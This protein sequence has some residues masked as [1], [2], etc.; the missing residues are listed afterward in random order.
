MGGIA[1]TAYKGT[2]PNSGGSTTISGRITIADAS[3]VFF[4]GDVLEKI[5]ANTGWT[6]GTVTGTCVYHSDDAGGGRMC[7][8]VVAAGA[9]HGD[10]GSPVFWQDSNGSYH[11]MGILWGGPDA[12]PG[13]QN[14]SEFWFS[15]R[16][17]IV[18]DLSPYNNLLVTPSG[19]GSGCVPQP[20]QICP[21]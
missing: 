10:S 13:G 7:N 12:V 2:G 3:T 1:R 11:L 6:A 14:S 9:N 19:G 18:D 21:V 5:G 4:A 20:G 17:S 15:R 8:G 16:Q